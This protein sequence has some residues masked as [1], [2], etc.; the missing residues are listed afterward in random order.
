MKDFENP[1]WEHPET[2]K[3]VSGQTLKI[4]SKTA[5]NQEMNGRD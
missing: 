3:I 1:T 5:D 2:L 4:I